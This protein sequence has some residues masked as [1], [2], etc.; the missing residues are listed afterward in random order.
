MKQL[1][2]FNNLKNPTSSDERCKKK[3]VKK[4]CMLLIRKKYIHLEKY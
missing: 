1:D 4:I 2:N 3:I